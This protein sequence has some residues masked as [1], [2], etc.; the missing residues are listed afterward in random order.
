VTRKRAVVVAAAGTLGMTAATVFAVTIP[1]D[2]PFGSVSSAPV[3]LSSSAVPSLLQTPAVTVPPA[4][5][6]P[7]AYVVLAGTKSLT[8]TAVAVAPPYWLLECN[9]Q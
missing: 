4:K 6:V 5:I 7:A 9:I 3:L 1:N 8:L 2:P